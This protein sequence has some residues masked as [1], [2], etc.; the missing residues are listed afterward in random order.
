MSELT[1]IRASVLHYIPSNVPSY[2][3]DTSAQPE[4]FPD[5]LL[6]IEDGRVKDVGPAEKLAAKGFDLD[7]AKHY[8]GK[9]I[10]PGLIDTH[11]HSPQIDVIGSYG[12][13]LLDWL[14]K[15]TF[16][17]EARY[18]DEAYARQRAD[19]FVNDLLHHGTT[20]AMVYA[21]A[22]ESATDLLFQAAHRENLR[23]IA[24]KVLMDQN[25]DACLLD[26]TAGGIDA[27]ER[28]ITKWH[29]TGRLSYC[30]TP[31]FAGSCT[32]GQLA[33]AG[34]LHARYPDTYLQTHI[35]ENVDEITWVKSLHPGAEDYLSIYESHGL[36]NER[37]T[38]GH[39]IHLTESERRR[40]GDKGAVA[41]FCPT[42]NLFLGSGLFDMAATRAAGVQVSIATDVGAGT[43]LSMIAT[44]GEAYKVCQLQGYSLS[45][46]EAFAMATIGNAKSLHLDHVVG[47]LAP[48]KEADFIVIDPTSNPLL[49]RRKASLDNIEDELFL[50]MTMGDDRLIAETWVA[51]RQVINKD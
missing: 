49:A 38:L 18:A 48:G 15:Y 27:S 20:T 36:I 21:T 26:E 30:I 1:A 32:P 14:N 22:H 41:A 35:S 37:M 25:A 40:I 8:P 10:L 33:A 51:G 29:G 17:A 23:L 11:V 13:Q 7:Q 19:D 9:L 50:Y 4:Y 44:L 5:G 31:R 43:S 24:G 39:C 34:E 45:P 46:H 47:N 2:E 6:L 3:S 16:P 12:E 28:L 42:S